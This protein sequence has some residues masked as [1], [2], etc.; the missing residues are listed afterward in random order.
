MPTTKKTTKKTKFELKQIAADTAVVVDRKFL[1]DLADK[2]YSSRNRKF[3]RLCHGV[4]QNGPDPKNPSRPMHCGLGEL[5]FQMTGYEPHETN[6]CEYE[7]VDL[8]VDKST[9]KDH[10]DGKVEAARGAI[11]DLRLP[12]ELKEMKQHLLNELN[13]ASKWNDRD[14]EDEECGAMAEELINFRSL[15]NS[16]PNI[17]DK[18]P[19]DDVCTDGD[20]KERAIRVAK[21]FRDAAKLLPW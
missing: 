13:E 8:I 21:V 15:I 14:V 6:V 10:F 11:E 2:I 16:I 12:V 9:L 1:R 19:S 7:V 20:Y 17:N 18:G 5:Y 4:L 3:L